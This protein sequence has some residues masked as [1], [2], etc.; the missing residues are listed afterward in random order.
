MTDYAEG[1]GF[2]YNEDYVRK[3]AG[4]DLLAGLT[5]GSQPGI[6]PERR[7]FRRQAW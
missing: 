7:P 4:L 5:D 2:T 1:E 6:P 3:T